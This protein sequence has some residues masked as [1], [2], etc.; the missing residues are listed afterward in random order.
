M[1]AY[2][3]FPRWSFATTCD[4]DSIGLGTP[5]WWIVV[6][7]PLQEDGLIAPTS[8]PPGGH[9]CRLTEPSNCAHHANCANSDQALWLPSMR[10]TH[11]NCFGNIVLYSP[12][13]MAFQ[14]SLR[15]PRETLSCLTRRCKIIVF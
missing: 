15:S 3:Q 9:F 13:N 14:T 10:K 5:G 8:L 6:V 4:R 2:L 12:A 11:A 1:E 7:T